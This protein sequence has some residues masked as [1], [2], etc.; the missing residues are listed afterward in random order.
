MTTTLVKRP[1]RITPPQTAST[2]LTIEPPPAR[3]Q[4]APAMA[5]LSMMMMPIMSGTGSI[6]V[7]ITQRDRPIVAVAAVLALIGSIAIGAVM[8]ITQRSGTKRQVRESRERYLDYVE[9]LRHTVRDQIAGQRAEQAWRFP[10]AEQLLDLARDDTRRWE[11]RRSHGD[12]LGVRLGTGEVPLAAGLTLEADTGP[13]NDFDPVCLQAAQEL[14]QRYATLRDQPIVLPLARVGTLSVIGSPPLRRDLATHLVLQTVTLQSPN[15]VQLAVVRSDETA[16]VWDWVKWLPHVQEAAVLDG[17][18]PARRVTSSVSAM[19]EMLAPELEARLDRFS[20]ARSETVSH[21]S[22]LVVVVDGEGLAAGQHLTSPDPAVPLASL[23]VHVVTL[24]DTPRAEPEAVDVRLEIDASGSVTSTVGPSPFRLDLA[25]R[26]IEHTI[27]RQLSALRLTVEDQGE[28]GLTDTV[29]LTEILGV[30]DPARLDLRRTWQPRALRDLLRVP[31]GV[32]T[33]GQP[34]LLDLKESAHGGMGPHGM[35]VGATGSGKSEMLRTMVSSL[36]IGHGPDRLALMLVDFKGG[37]TFASM[38]HIPHIAGMITNLQDDLTLVDR[39]R[40]ALYGE[41]QR[42][43]EI[44]KRA[45]NLPNV[46]AYQD[47]IDAGE[48]LEPLP[49]LLVIIDEFSELLTAKPDFAEM[50][51]AIGRIGRSIG[52]HLLL[53]TQ[54][55][56][57]GKIRG[58]ESHLSYRIS[59]RTFSEAESRDAIGVPDAFHLPPE[60]GSGYLKVDTTVFDRFKAAL[61]SQPYVPPSDGPKTSVPVVPYVATN[62]LGAWLAQ[63]AAAAEQLEAEALAA[64]VSRSDPSVLDVICEQIETA[65]SAPVRPVWLDPLPSRLALGDLVQVGDRAPATSCRAVLGTVDDPKHQ[66]QFPLEWDFTGGGANLIVTGSPQTGKSTLVRT[67]ILSMAA[68]Y[69]PGDVAFY[70]VDYGGGSLTALQD[71]PHVA[72]V[73]SRVDPEKIRRTVNDV[74]STLDRREA[75]FRERGYDSMAA[76]RRARANGDVDTSEP[77]DVFLVVDGWGTFRDEYDDLDYA[78]AD[79]AA[80]GTNFGVHVVITVTQGMQVRMRMQGSMGGR[81]ELRLNDAYD[82]EFER[83]VME[84]IPKDSLGRGI[85]GS[86]KEAHIFQTALPVLAV[87]ADPDDD[88]YAALDDDQRALVAAVVEQW[89]GQA[90]QRVQVLPRRVEL[91]ELPAVEKG[92]KGVLV[93]LSE[94]NLGPAEIQLWGADPH[95]QVYGDG[96]TGKSN[97]LKLLIH[98][99]VSSHGPDE[100]GI[101]VVDYRRSLLDVVPEEYLLSYATSAEQTAQ[102]AHDLTGAIQARVPGPDVTSE[103]LRNR[104]WWNGLEV[105]LIVDDYDLVAT[106]QGDPLGPVVDLLPQGRDL[107]FHLVLSRRTGGMSRAV[108]APMIQR[109]IDLSAPGFM[110]SGDRLEGR[111]IG[112]H[113]SQRLPVGRAMYVTRDGGASLVQTAVMPDDEPP[114]T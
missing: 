71:V 22:H 59:L 105:F 39:M 109:L 37:A 9:A 27:A 41:M 1:A 93:G 66:A 52:V 86:R 18:V 5:G 54:K 53:A 46:T 57:M 43:Q 2:P 4:G 90:V 65:G 106:S 108:F 77:G 73:T 99:L 111:L 95:L 80:R 102:L 87:S 112:G 97:L 81:L 25:P 82:S 94:L 64:T 17:D 44:L 55:L 8:L 69:A 63:Q 51:V 88:E 60:P 74:R 56:E 75:M 28:D 33:A 6:T 31:I 61:V 100:I 76:Y 3:G 35:V 110:F 10:R 113:A 114:R 36:V 38:E 68:T 23:G 19:A 24:L 7:A 89:K 91:A 26:G 13:L 84:Q 70:V 72:S 14:Q 47:R 83:S 12:F 20:R 49:H 107:G 78:I 96:E 62:G 11:R 15:D 103:Q 34:V 16:A 104:S 30:D 21:P 58:L 40:D 50:F 42:R 29:G 32:G 101:A 79:V 45:G 85:T 92:D 67:M 98:N 48:D